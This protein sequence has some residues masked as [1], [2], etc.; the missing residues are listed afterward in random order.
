MYQFSL[1]V[2]PEQWECGLF[3]N[4]LPVCGYILLLLAGLT[5]LASVGEEVLGCVKA[6]MP[7]RGDIQG[8][9]DLLIGE[10]E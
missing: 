3:P 7:G 6:L 1:H 5:C 10:G 8:A 2:G 9:P 4:L